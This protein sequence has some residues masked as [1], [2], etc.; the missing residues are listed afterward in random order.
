[1]MRT[2]KNGRMKKSNAVKKVFY[3]MYPVIV[4]MTRKN[5]R[6]R[7]SNAAT[8][9]HMATICYVTHSGVSM[10]IIQEVITML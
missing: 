3:A 10:S 5:G 7:K 8:E 4:M 6:R 1:M 9:S 2:K